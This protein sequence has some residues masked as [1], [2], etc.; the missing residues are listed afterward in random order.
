M[1]VTLAVQLLSPS[2][3]S[4]CGALTPLLVTLVMLTW[5]SVRDWRL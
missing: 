3:R 1:K 2:L 4:L 5:A